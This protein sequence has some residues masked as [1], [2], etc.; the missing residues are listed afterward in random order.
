M[1]RE[2]F[3]LLKQVSDPHQ[4]ADELLKKWHRGV[5]S[6][7]EAEAVS[8]FLFKLGMHKSLVAEMSYQF[9]KSSPL[10]VRPLLRLMQRYFTAE[11]LNPDLLK[12]LY[13]WCEAEGK[14]ED[15]LRME[16]LVQSSEKLEKLRDLALRESLGFSQREFAKQLRNIEAHL[17]NQDYELADAAIENLRSQYAGHAALEP[18]SQKLDFQKALQTLKQRAKDPELKI[19]FD[20]VY[21]DNELREDWSE[22]LPALCLAHPDWQYDIAIA[23]FAM[24]LYSDSIALLKS[25]PQ[26]SAQLFLVK[27]FMQSRRYHEA[28]EHIEILLKDAAIGDRHQLHLYYQQAICFYNVGETQTAIEALQ[29]LLKAKADHPGAGSLLAKWQ[30]ES[31]A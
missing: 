31:K 6:I 10:P 19:N 27:A 7:K 1:E 5:L 14:V 12:V 21:A 26:E 8:E 18:L 20:L 3:K 4:I 25:L 23:L 22:S 17:V 2:I 24:G 28:L 30:A 11:D 15:L 16:L 29:S 9:S 13:L